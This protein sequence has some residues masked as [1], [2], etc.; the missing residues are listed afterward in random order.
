MYR[1]RYISVVLARLRGL[2]SVSSKGLVVLGELAEG[3]LGL[4]LHEVTERVPRV[5]FTWSDGKGA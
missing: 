2:S 1:M 5:S 4:V 3:C